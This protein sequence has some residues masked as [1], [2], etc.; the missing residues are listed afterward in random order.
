MCSSY[1]LAVVT[2]DSSLFTG[3]HSPLTT[4]K[5][6]LPA[7]FSRNQVHSRQAAIE[8]LWIYPG[9]LRGCPPLGG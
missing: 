5:T 4:A 2:H 1:I 3:R 8:F 7:I 6:S 9:A